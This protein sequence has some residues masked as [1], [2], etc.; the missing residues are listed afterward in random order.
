MVDPTMNDKYVAIFE[1]TK[2]AISLWSFLLGLRVVPLVV[3]PWYYFA[4]TVG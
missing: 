1:A 2:E 3:L 4:I